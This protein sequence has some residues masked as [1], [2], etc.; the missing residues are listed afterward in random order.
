MRTRIP[1]RY[2][3]V[4]VTEIPHVILR[5]AV[6]I[7]GNRFF[8]YAAENL[9]PKWFTKDPA[10]TVHD[11][12]QV[13]LRVIESACDV[14]RAAGRHRSVF[15]WW[16]HVYQ[17][18]S[19]WAG[20]WAIPPL[21]AHLGTSLVERAMIDAFCRAHEV[22]FASAVRENRFD[23]RLGDFHG[24][25]K[26]AQPKDFLPEK[27]LRSL[28]ARHTIG[29]TDPLTGSASVDDLPESLEA[30]IAA[31]GLTHFKIKLSGDPVAD[32]E[33]LRHVAKVLRPPCWFTLDANEN[34][35]YIDAFR[36]FWSALRNDSSVSGFMSRLLFV[37]Q[38][39]H[40]SVAFTDE[41]KNWEDRPPIIV[42][43]SDADICSAE[44]ALDAG[45]AGTSHKNCKGVIKSIA[46]ACL[47]SH[48]RRTDPS[49]QF[50][51]SAEDLTTVGPIALL[52]DLA[53]AATLGVEHLERNGHHYFRGLSMFPTDVMKPVAC[54]HRDIFRTLADGIPAVQIDGGRINVA[55]AVEAPFG[56][57]ILFDWNSL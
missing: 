48:R 41:W 47:L 17:G 51:L 36:R 35:P 57:E 24:E 50:I 10:T 49:R 54:H 25:L 21:L 31:Y 1:F 44:R 33:R 13:M 55:S 28:I 3:I 52:E 23:I 27:P 46:N 38:P 56:P 32:V 7:D 45:Y 9:A 8:G 12:E 29:L 6:E 42:D 16:M 19:T 26:N 20:G 11:D 53:V 34:F 30:C 37:E 39:L 18:Q 2:G 4:T 15:D 5:A 14:A 43:E 40:R 22:A